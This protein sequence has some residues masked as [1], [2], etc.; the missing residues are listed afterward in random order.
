M[1]DGIKKQS[2]NPSKLEEYDSGLISQI[3]RLESQLRHDF[4]QLSL[5]L[6]P[7]GFL[8]IISNGGRIGKEVMRKIFQ[9]ADSQGLSVTG[10]N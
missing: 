2:S 10:G 8:H 7:G 1:L 4:P 6:R 9:F 5:A 3:K